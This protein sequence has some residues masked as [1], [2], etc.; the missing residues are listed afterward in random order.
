VG[1]PVGQGLGDNGWS[2]NFP[3]FPIS[4][5]IMGQMRESLLELYVAQSPSGTASPPGRKSRDEAASE[6]TTSPDGELFLVEASASYSTST[7]RGGNSL[8]SRPNNSKQP[9]S[10][11]PSTLLATPPPSALTDTTTI[12]ADFYFHETARIYSV[13]D[14]H[15]NPFRSFVG[16]LWGDSRLIYCAMQSMAAMGLENLYPRLCVTGAEMR[17]EAVNILASNEE[18]CNET[19]L[20]ALLMIGVTSSWHDP[21]DGGVFL[22]RSF[23]ERMGMIMEG[24]YSLKS[25]NNYQFFLESLVYWQ[26][27]LSYVVDD[28]RLRCLSVPITP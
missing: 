15:M 5:E 27:L 21:A 11:N 9:K 25:G 28:S 1:H 18:D 7:S 16:Q 24:K 26:M 20:L 8:E 6:T 12:L 3:T 19:S 14:G 22:F 17:R 2:E 13:F 23:Q 10:R 4:P